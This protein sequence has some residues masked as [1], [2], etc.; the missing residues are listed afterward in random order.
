[1]LGG[2]RWISEVLPEKHKLVSDGAISHAR[3]KLGVEVF[4]VLWNKL[5]ASF[6]SLTGDFH[7]LTTVIFD[8]STGTM[9]DTQANRDAF[10]KPS[11]RRGT[12]KPTCYRLK[13]PSACSSTWPRYHGEPLPCRHHHCNDDTRQTV[14][15]AILVYDRDMKS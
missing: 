13:F 3:V 1:M 6:Q 9:P 7:G 15:R 8:G 12:A 2:F 10:G 14:D 5:V 4:R 11:A